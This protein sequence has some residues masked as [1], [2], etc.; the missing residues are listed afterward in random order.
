[1]THPHA[2]FLTTEVRQASHP[3]AVRFF[4]TDDLR[5][6]FHIDG[7]FN[8]GHIKL[9]YTHVDR[10]VVGGATPSNTP[11]TLSSGKFVGTPGFMDR[12]ELG[13]VNVGG[14]GTVS[15]QGHAHALETRDALYV[16]MG[17]GD[18]TFTSADA[19]NPAKFYLLSAP[20][21]Q[22]YPT[23]LITED[24]AKRIDLG[25][26][27][28]ANVR[29]I[30]QM[31]HP[32]VCQSCQLVMGMT[33]LAP[34]S[35]WNTMPCHVHD[36][37]SEIY[38]YFDLTSDARVFH[39]MGEPSET[40]HMVIANEDAVISPGWSIHSGCGTRNYSFIWAMA[41]DNQDFTD[42]QFVKMEDLR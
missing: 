2:D 21:H 8:A 40:R 15:V 24:K 27:E 17:A 11:L 5:A 39:F 16:G 1:M 41:G 34:G 3:D 13:I 36:A 9:V 19:T 10:F 7:L 4:D 25:S 18:L 23:V 6:H 37:R 22:S 32:D 35:I 31:I 30:F 28:N 12:R 42:M 14:K 33:R 26:P 29:T 38:L 20:A